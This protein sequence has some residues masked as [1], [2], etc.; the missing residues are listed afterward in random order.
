MKGST[1]SLVKQMPIASKKHH[2]GVGLIEVMV[3]LLVIS[4]GVLGMAGL[5]TKSLQ[6]NQFSYLRS[7]AVIIVNDM[8]DRIRANRTVAASGSEYVVNETQHVA[9]GCTTNDF[10]NSCESGTCSESQLATYDLQQWKFQ[11]ACQLPDATGSIAIEN[12]TS[13]RVYVITLKFNDSHGAQAAR[14]V[15][16]RSAL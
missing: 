15:V 3:A 4:V 16:L 10:V 14:E 6:Q 12:T 7:Q 5:Q 9:T 8:M 13:G 1:R 11:M 2:K